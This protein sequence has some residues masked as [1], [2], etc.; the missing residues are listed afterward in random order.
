[1][2]G[3]Q[4]VEPTEQ[5]FTFKAQRAPVLGAKQAASRPQKHRQSSVPKPFQLST[6]VSHHLHVCTGTNLQRCHR[7]L[8]M[9]FPHSSVIIVQAQLRLATC[10]TV[11]TQ[12]RRAETAMQA[13]GMAKRS[14][15]SEAEPVQAAP[16]FHAAPVPK[17]L[18]QPAKL[19]AIPEA[20]P[21]EQE[22]FRLLS[23][24][25][26]QQVRPALLFLLRCPQTKR[27]SE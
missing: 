10:P 8:H 24:A 18:Y 7:T 27:P 17:S 13:R 4:L 5:P 15:V 23:E 20:R 9:H 11:D 2:Q 22:A 3:M 14:G 16:A 19:P 25:R 12:L 6:D 1:M 21:T 26:H